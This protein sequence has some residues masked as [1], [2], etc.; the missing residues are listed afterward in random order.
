LSAS[1]SVPIAERIAWYCLLAIPVA[2]PLAVG[3]APFTGGNPFL[4]D[5]FVVPKLAA[6]GT[7][8]GVGLM[9]LATGW[10]MGSVPLR[11]VPRKWL[12]LAFFILAA[13]ATAVAL[14]PLSAI[15]GGSAQR[16]GLLA[17]SL[18]GGTF[19]LAS[20]LVV[21]KQRMTELARSVMAG[22]ALVAAIG[23]VQAM[24]YDPVGVQ[25]AELWMIGRGTS[26]IGNS[27]W[28]GTYLVLPTVLA[29]GLALAERSRALRILASACFAALALGLL[30][31]LTRGAWLATLVGV[32]TLGFA[33]WRSGSRLSKSSLWAIAAALGILATG[34]AVKFSAIAPRFLDLS[35]GI[36]KA[37]GGRIVPWKEA[38]A[39]IGQHPLFGVGPDSFRLG[40]FPI[41]TLA[42]L[43]TGAS[44]VAEDPHNTI[45]LLAATVGVP[46][47]LVAAATPLAGLISGARD[48]FPRGAQS[49]RLIY[50]SWWAAL[51]AVCVA[52]M[53]SLNTIVIMALVALAIAVVAAPAS[54]ALK[55]A[56]WI[57]WTLAGLAVALAVPL[58]AFPAMS[59]GSDYQMAQAMTGDTALSSQRA[60][61][62]A[63][64]NYAARNQHAFAL[65][66]AAINAL[67]NKS[68]DAQALFETADAASAQLIAWNPY[69]HD[70]YLLRASLLTDA[71]AYLGQSTLNSAIDAADKGL[72]VQPNSLPLRMVKVDA[73]SQLGRWQE[74]VDTL[75]GI[76]DAD[77]AYALPGTA[78]AEALVRIGRTT[79]AG[80]VIKELR[81]RFSA[82]PA[83]MADIARIEAIKP[84]SK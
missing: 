62:I 75:T 59:L 37:S 19:L 30:L 33:F 28:T 39:V 29:A 57:Q 36:D 72:T 25:I 46:A 67:K 4:Y 2:V 52:L 23:L 47:M 54:R 16:V 5:P 51:L 69:E 42:S 60:I 12:I 15:F 76:W 74:V 49:D 58:I 78:Y 14:H 27:D 10:A 61:D 56:N 77:P 80:A 11:T 68:S 73:L 43:S 71:G 70:S 17:F 66:A 1:R 22:G 82:D 41:R 81:S 20:Q 53:F 38:L 50:S 18:A 34:V 45:L 65:S 63:P 40:W 32:A 79:E 48:A 9:S 26:T 21:G 31:T 83:V 3:H 64:W 55:T 6:L 13:V 8:V 35:K 44:G 84:G 7:L 24:G